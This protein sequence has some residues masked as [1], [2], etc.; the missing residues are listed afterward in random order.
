MPHVRRVRHLRFPNGSDLLAWEERCADDIGAKLD[1][2][3]QAGGC[4]PRWRLTL[5]PGFNRL[6][7]HVEC[8]GKNR[9]RDIKVMP[10]LPDIRSIELRRRFR[11]DFPSGHGVPPHRGR[12]SCAALD[13]DHFTHGLDEPLAKSLAGLPTSLRL[14]APH[15]GSIV[16][17]TIHATGRP[18]NARSGDKYETKR[19]AL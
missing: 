10:D 19:A 15:L 8:R 17:N 3:K 5:L 2:L 18:F 1:D 16:T 7:T 4:S 6:R 12:L 14:D 11:F 13:G 9:L